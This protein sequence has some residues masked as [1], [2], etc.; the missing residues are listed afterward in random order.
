MADVA[1]G[2]ASSSPEPL[3]LITEVFLHKQVE[4]LTVALMAQEG[5]LQWVREDRDAAQAEKEA[6]ERV[7]NTSVR[8]VLERVPEVQGL[9][10][11]LTQQE[12]WPMEEAEEQEMAP[13]AGLLWAEL[14]IARRRKD[15]LANKAASGR[16]GILRKLGVGALD[17]LGRCLHGVRVD[18]RRVGTD[19][20]GSASGIAA[21][22]GE[23]GE[24]AGG[25]SMA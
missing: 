15:W 5:E 7:W 2:R 23:G 19:A 10:E 14:E 20:R 16:V 21:E 17:S 11:H 8:V 9:R 24:I 1:L 18:P 13:E 3:P 4:V 25:A 12:V 22:D 6:L